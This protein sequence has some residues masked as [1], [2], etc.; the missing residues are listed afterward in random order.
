M[1]SPVRSQFQLNC[2]V[3]VGHGVAWAVFVTPLNRELLTDSFDETLLRQR[4]II[5]RELSND[6]SSQLVVNPTTVQLVNYIECID[7]DPVNG[8]R[9]RGQRVNVTIYGI[10]LCTIMHAEIEDDFEFTGPPSPPTDVMLTP[11][12]VNSLRVSWSSPPIPPG[13]T[14][15]FNLTIFNLN[16]SSSEPVLMRT[17]I[18][19]QHYIFTDGNRAR[20]CD[21][22]SFQVTARND[23]GMGNPSEIITGSL[24]SLPDMSAVEDSLQHSLAKADGSVTMRVQFNVNKL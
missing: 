1:I 17:D 21:V 12:T 11:I 5:V 23:A 3:A 13:V 4:G 24:P 15:Y 10:K 16:S 2:S 22:Y 8:S 19:T 20:P 14:L 6:H 18:Q 9:S 7:T